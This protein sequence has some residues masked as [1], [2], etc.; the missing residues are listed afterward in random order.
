MYTAHIYNNNFQDL[1]INVYSALS[2]LKKLHFSS[3]IVMGLQLISLKV[4]LYM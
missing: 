4:S 1:K 2:Q 3:F